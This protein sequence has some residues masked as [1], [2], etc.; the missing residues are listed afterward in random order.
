[1]SN[2]IKVIIFALISSAVLYFFPGKYLMLLYVAISI[3]FMLR[4]AS[5]QKIEVIPDEEYKSLEK[6]I[7]KFPSRLDQARK[8]AYLG[9]VID[10]IGA[11]EETVQ[12]NRRNL[13]FELVSKGDRVV[14]VRL[15]IEHEN[16]G[17]I[18]FYPMYTAEHCKMKSEYVS[19]GRSPKAQPAT[20]EV[21]QQQ[22]PQV[23]QQRQRSKP[24]RPPMP[25]EPPAMA[26]WASL[27]PPEYQ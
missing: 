25:P 3:P 24:P 14:A 19:R 4:A 5:K 15:G 10:A 20:K 22:K 17:H 23:K 8:E 11:N 18:F 7:K 16:Q 26:E 13:V 9:G 21:K 1:M 6:Q 2:Q 12:R 27:P